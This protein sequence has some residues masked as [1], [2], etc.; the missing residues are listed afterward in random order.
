MPPGSRRGRCLPLANKC[1][2]PAPPVLNCRGPARP[3]NFTPRHPFLQ[4]CTITESEQKEPPWHP[5]PPVWPFSR[6]SVWVETA[7][8]FARHFP[9]AKK[10]RTDAMLQRGDRIRWTLQRRI[11]GD[12]ISSWN[13][14]RTEKNRFFRNWTGRFILESSLW[15]SRAVILYFVICVSANVKWNNQIDQSDGSWIFLSLQLLE[16]YCYFCVILNKYRFSFR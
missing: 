15:P 12:R 1:N 14:D 10:L 5:V 7:V 3:G 11:D 16:R 13:F 4:L 2:F 9:R 8:R 6:G